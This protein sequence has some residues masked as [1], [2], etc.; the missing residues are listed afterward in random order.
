MVTINILVS[1]S[2]VT[3]LE[4]AA[5]MVPSTGLDEVPN[6]NL[7]LRVIHGEVD[8]S[9]AFKSFKRRKSLAVIAD[10]REYILS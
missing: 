5:Q 10:A 9:L 1:C 3:C 6:G 2:K 7:P 4:S 8:E